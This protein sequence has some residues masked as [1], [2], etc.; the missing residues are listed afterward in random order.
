MSTKRW[1]W[2]FGAIFA[3]LIVV[4]CLISLCSTEKDSVGVFQNGVLL[5]EI[6][7]SAGEQLYTVTYEGRKNTIHV[8]NGKVSV[9]DADCPDHIC[10]LHGALEKGNPIVC[11]PNRLVIR[12]ISDETEYADAV[13][14]R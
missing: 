11:L 8:E 13:T 14:G 3:I 6:D 4:I 9:S 12:F 10:V 5:Y 7:V 2:L 1:I